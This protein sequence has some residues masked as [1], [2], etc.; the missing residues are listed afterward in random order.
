MRFPWLAALCLLPLP[1]QAQSPRPPGAAQPSRPSSSPHP[2][3][4]EDMLALES[5]GQ[6]Q[7]D[8]SGRIAL[9]ERRRAWRDAPRFDYGIRT[10]WLNSRLNVLDLARPGRPAP[11]FPQDRGAGYWSGGFSPS[12]RRLAVFRLAETRLSLGVVDMATR[13][14]RWF[15]LAPDLLFPDPR[16]IWLDD[17]RLIY[18]GRPR[19]TLPRALAGGWGNRRM[20]EMLERAARGRDSSVTLY[21]SGA[22]RDIATRYDDNEVVQADARTGAVRALLT[23]SVADIALAPGGRHLAVVQR[24]EVVQPDPER[25]VAPSFQ[26]RRLRLAI[27]DLVNGAIVRICATCDLLPNLLSWSRSGEELLFHARQDDQDWA[28]GQ[29]YRT[30]AAGPPR[31]AAPALEAEVRD[32]TGSNLSLAADWLGDTPVLRARPR[33]QTGP[34][35]W[36][37]VEDGEPA[38]MD[39]EPGDQLIAA[40]PTALLWRSGTTLVRRGSAHGRPLPQAPVRA[41]GPS[42]LDIAS[43]GARALT[44][45]RDRPVPITLG[46]ANGA[47]VILYDPSLGAVRWTQPLPAGRGRLLAAAANGAMLSLGQEPGGAAVLTLS[48]PGIA[49]LP[50]DVINRHLEASAPLRRIAVQTPGPNGRALTHW[51]TL[52]AVN[53]PDTPLVVLPYPGT[54][55]PDGTPPPVDPSQ[56]NPVVNPALLAGAG[57]AVLEPSIPLAQAGAADDVAQM[58]TG[59]TTV[60]RPRR[61]SDPGAEDIAAVSLRIVEAAIE[62]AH[63]AGQASGERVALY[64]QSFGA[65]SAV[66]MATRTDRFRAIVAE[67]GPY[68]FFAGYGLLAPTIDHGEAGFSLTAAFGWYED[69]QGSIGGPPWRMA[70]TYVRQSP[71]FAAD[72]IRTPMLLI[73]GD[74]DFAP[75]SSAER[76]LLSMHRLGRDALL[77]R[78]GGEGHFNVGPANIRDQWRRLI[79]FLDTHLRPAAPARDPDARP[80][81]PHNPQ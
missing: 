20:T 30:G 60:L 80:D 24:G 62:A 19:G 2:Y 28:E 53:G 6:V 57:Y 13:R 1:A 3:G 25:P 16:P 36:Y 64:G 55:R 68:D 31:A 61:Q 43:T 48:R 33:G 70:E 14:V 21:G 4:V 81:A 44:P 7:I 75:Y 40:G 52:P 8:P 17:D 72:R 79:A 74:M 23:G 18:A 77:L 71:L 50:V 34:Y 29:L 41:V 51:L 65:W 59:G 9:I 69:G 38:P 67:A 5:Y 46:G 63:A 73:H 27:V 66:A 15:A 10:V 42:L 22:Y 37:R 54:V 11:L 12:G 32:L 35:R 58:T 39:A 78:Y 56:F 49:P 26:P 47:S 45:A 76:L